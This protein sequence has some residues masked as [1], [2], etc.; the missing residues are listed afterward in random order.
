MLGTVHHV[1]YVVEDIDEGI[2][3]IEK[4]YDLELE[5]KNSDEHRQE[6]GIDAALF[7]TGESVLELISPAE[8]LGHGGWAADV[9][10]ENGEGFFHLAYEVDDIEDAKQRLE[11][12]GI[13]FK[14]D[15][16]GQ[17]FIGQS[18]E[19]TRLLTLKEEYTL[20]PTQIVEEKN[21]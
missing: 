3:H 21:K 1:A 16:I 18:G 6:H 2:E 17:G 7:F 13:E 11:E 15:E 8:D 10:E 4:T 5:R 9:L 19:R 20:L 12:K 14:E